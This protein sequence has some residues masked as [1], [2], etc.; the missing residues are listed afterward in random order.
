MK[1][2]NKVNRIGVRL[3]NEEAEALDYILEYRDTNISKFI[4]NAIINEKQKIDKEKSDKYFKN[5]VKGV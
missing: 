4:V 2:K 5:L 1:K 3:S